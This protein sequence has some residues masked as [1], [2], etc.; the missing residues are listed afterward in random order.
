VTDDPQPVDVPA[1]PPADRSDALVPEGDLVSDESATL[2]FAFT[3]G[4][5]RR[6]RVGVAGIAAIVWF[7]GLV[8]LVVA[9]RL[10]GRSGVVGLLVLAVALGAAA[11]L[12]GRTRPVLLLDATSARARWGLRRLAVQWQDV[13]GVV[14]RDRGTA[15]RIVLQRADGHTVLPVPLTGGSILSP[16]PDPGLDHKADLIRRWWEDHHSP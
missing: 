13:T 7:L 9:G 14:V 8:R 4:Q 12:I 10:T 5:C 15:R 11:W 1:D 6:Y 2:V 16:G 3:A